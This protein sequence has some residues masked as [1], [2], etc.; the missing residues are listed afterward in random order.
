MKILMIED[1]FHPQA[2]YQLNVLAPYLVKY[3]HEVT[4]MCGE[5]DRFPDYLTGFFGKDGL[6]DKDRSFTEETGVKII[7]IPVQKYISGRAIFDKIV[8]EK[9]KEMT[10]DV[11]YAHGNDSYNG[12]QFLLKQKMFNCPV[13]SDSHMVDMASTNKFASVYRA[14]YRLFVTP[15]IKKNKNIIIRTVD[16]PF[17]IKSYGIPKEQAPVVGFGSDTRKFHPD[18]SV[19]AEMRRELGISDDE[20]VVVYAG[21]LDEFKGGLF[22][23]ESIHDKIEIQGA[24]LRFLLIGNISGD[25]AKET[26][27]LLDQSENN[28]LMYPTQVYSDLPKW[29]QTA[30]VAIFPKQCSLTYYD[31]LACGL[32]VLVEDNPIGEQR[33][34]ECG[35]TFTFKSGNK[36]NFRNKLIEIV[37]AIMMEKENNEKHRFEDIALD[38]I[39]KNY[40]YEK[41]AR[42][43]EKIITDVFNQNNDNKLKITER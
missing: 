20:I 7:R 22:L 31:V 5:M 16:D 37:N 39:L 30:D 36:D 29:F 6:S 21:K 3:G 8:F 40:N 27:E 19:K 34:K 9:A 12:M 35:A 11:I 24:K 38:Y 26:G 2:G 25:K 28:L 17:I 41:Q 15:V 4:I 43:Y 14:I 32:P 10:P 13:L 42:E 33:A 23:A 18:K 1:F